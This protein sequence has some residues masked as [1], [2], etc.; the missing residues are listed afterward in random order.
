MTEATESK[1]SVRVIVHSFFVIPFLVA[2][3][4]VLVFFIW[5]LLTYEPRG[6]EDY[7]T[8][9]KIGGATKRWQ[10]AYELSKI[11]ASPGWA[12][13]GDRFSAEMLSAYEYALRDPDTRVRQYLI[14][15]MGN[16]GLPE[17]SEIIQSALLEPD[18]AVVADAVYALGLIGGDQN[19]A[20]IIEMVQHQSSLVRNRSAI[21]LGNLGLQDCIFPLQKLLHDVEPNVR[22]NAAVSLAKLGSDRGRDVLLSLLQRGYLDQFDD[23]DP[24]EQTEAMLTAINAATILEDPSLNAAILK[25]SQED[26]NMKVRDAAIKALNL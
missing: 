17:F 2:A 23:V 12:P 19:L 7:I 26:M 18:A 15:A 4:S 5:S 13:Q 9:I 1:S 22:W 10:S 24:Y 16:S 6:A 25:L 14:R 8:D 21:A 11:L 3:F 20:P